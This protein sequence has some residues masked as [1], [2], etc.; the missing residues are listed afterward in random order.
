MLGWSRRDGSPVSQGEV[1]DVWN[2]RC[3]AVGNV[4][5]RAGD[6]HSDR[7]LSAAA[8]VVVHDALFDEIEAEP[9]S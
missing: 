1:Y 6:H 5:V 3:A 7:T 8:R 4:G 9:I 2:D